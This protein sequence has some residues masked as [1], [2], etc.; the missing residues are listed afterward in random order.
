LFCDLVLTFLPL[1]NEK[2]QQHKS[3]VSKEHHMLLLHSKKPLCLDR[4]ANVVIL[5]S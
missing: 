2:Q 3:G 4:S 5:Y 1:L